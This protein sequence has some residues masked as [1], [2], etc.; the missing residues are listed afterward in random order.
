MNKGFKYTQRISLLSCRQSLTRNGL[1]FALFLFLLAGLAVPF[2]AYSR[3]DQ[4]YKIKAAFIYRFLLF[5]E[6]PETAY[7]GADRKII[8]GIMGQNPFEDFFKQV[9]GTPVDGR[10]LEIR[11]FPADAP[12]EK[13]QHCQLLFVCASLKDQYK[14]VIGLLKD[15]PVLTVGDIDGFA[16]A[17]GLIGFYVEASGVKFAINRTAAKRA[18]LMLRSQLLRVAPRIVE[19]NHGKNEDAN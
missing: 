16:E 14:E 18:G 3:N 4:I 7:A 17:G 8:I 12:L 9:E 11:H 19:I 15:L 1:T 13:I 10:T 6:W 2:T 5:T